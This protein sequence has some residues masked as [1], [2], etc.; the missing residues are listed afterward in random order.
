MSGRAKPAGDVGPDPNRVS[1]FELQ[2]ALKDPT[3]N[4]AFVPAVAPVPHSGQLVVMPH[5]DPYS[6]LTK[7]RSKRVVQGHNAASHN[8]IIA[9]RPQPAYD[10]AQHAEVAPHRVAPFATAH[11]ALEG[12]GAEHLL[13]GTRSLTPTR[14]RGTPSPR[15]SRQFSQ[16]NS[17]SAESPFSPCAEE[18]PRDSGAQ[19]RAMSP[20]RAT[21]PTRH[22]ITGDGCDDSSTRKGKAK[23]ATHSRNA[24]VAEALLSHD[25]SAPVATELLGPQSQRAIPK[26]K[27]LPGRQE[28][29]QAVHERVLGNGTCPNR[30]RAHARASGKMVNFTHLQQILASLG[31]AYTCTWAYLRSDRLYIQCREYADTDVVTVAMQAPA[32]PTFNPHAHDGPPESRQ[33]GKAV[34]E[35]AHHRN[36]CSVGGFRFGSSEAVHLRASEERRLEKLASDHPRLN[37]NPTAGHDIS[38][39]KLIAAG[40]AASHLITHEPA[41]LQAP[42]AVVA[43]EPLG[44]IKEA[45]PYHHVVAA[46]AA[47]EPSPEQQLD[48]LYSSWRSPSSSDIAPTSSKGAAGAAVPNRRYSSSTAASSALE[49]RVTRRRGSEVVIKM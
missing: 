39:H 45:A 24:F 37:K 6:S 38:A 4:A 34:A 8:H 23:V 22:P 32:K 27:K 43:P 11:N 3:S 19:G 15:R 9:I 17:S 49:G 5:H 31:F 48:S 36:T 18:S 26:R 16:R 14:L 44:P 47:P 28:D 33:S 1:F 21:T 42:F 25:S 13:S 12:G 30:V 10:P 35:G 41:H 40:N 46:S 2:A 7:H 29:P 20:S